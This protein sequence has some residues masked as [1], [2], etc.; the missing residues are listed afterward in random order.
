MKKLSRPQFDALRYASGR[1]LYARDVNEGNGNMRRTL[2]WLIE[3]ELLAWDPIYHGRLVLTET[4]SQ[5]LAD[6]RQR[7]RGI[8]RP[9]ILR[10]RDAG[11]QRVITLS[12]EHKEEP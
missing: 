2:L 6:E 4:G 8:D 11:D 5:K 9:G 3:H 10:I 12:G 1:Q 7:Q